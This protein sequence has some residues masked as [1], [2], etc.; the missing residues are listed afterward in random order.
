MVCDVPLIYMWHV[1]YL[2]VVF[3][4]YAR[5][6]TYA[7]QTLDLPENI[8]GLDGFCSFFLELVLH[9]GNLA[10]QTSEL[11]F[12]GFQFLEFDVVIAESAG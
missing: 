3:V 9:T 8:C 7:R 12:C 11:F 5:V 6:C 10:G 1:S 2:I 4:I